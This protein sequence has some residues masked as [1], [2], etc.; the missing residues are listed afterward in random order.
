M[1]TRNSELDYSQAT[2]HPPSESAADPW[3]WFARRERLIYL[4]RKIPELHFTEPF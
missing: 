4:V 3:S 1:E 2:H